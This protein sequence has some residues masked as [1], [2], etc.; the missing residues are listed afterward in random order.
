MGIQKYFLK[1]KFENEPERGRATTE[2]V[3]SRTKN[4]NWRKYKVGIQAAA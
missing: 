1:I 4:R 2:K 3:P